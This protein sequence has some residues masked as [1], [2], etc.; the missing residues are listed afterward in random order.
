MAAWL[1]EP[2]DRQ[3]R[4][5][6]SVKATPLGPGGPDTDHT[7]R[8]S[9]LSLL[10]LVEEIT[11]RPHLPS[12]VALER[13]KPVIHCGQ[14]H[15]FQMVE[16]VSPSGLFANQS[17]LAKNLQVLGDGRPP[18]YEQTGEVTGRPRTPTEDLEDLATHRIGKRTEDVVSHPRTV[19]RSLPTCQCSPTRPHPGPRWLPL[20]PERSGCGE[21][22]GP[23][24]QPSGFG[25]GDRG[26]WRWW[27]QGRTISPHPGNRFPQ[28]PGK[29]SPAVGRWRE[30]KPPMR[31]TKQRPELSPPLSVDD[32]LRPQLEHCSTS[33][34]IAELARRGVFRD[35]PELPMAE[36]R[37][38][39]EREG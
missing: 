19:R 15:G 33:A 7:P 17:H 1:G 30:R 28:S 26:W 9:S 25:P 32:L 6:K 5:K 27:D 20:H 16:A 12:P 35:V 34:L 18:L 13:M 29:V 14:R 39:E 11:Q 2:T 24:P 23:G 22:Y 4:W 31:L 10:L 21:R 37:S 8:S 38:I 36:W 3:A